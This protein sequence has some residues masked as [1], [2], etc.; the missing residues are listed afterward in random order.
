MTYTH[1]EIQTAKWLASAS[2]H[3]PNP[4]AFEY[5]LPKAR[6]LNTES[7]ERMARPFTPEREPDVTIQNGLYEIGL[8]VE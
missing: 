8:G 6:Q 5:F 2:Q 3:G 1:R 7:A 4:Q